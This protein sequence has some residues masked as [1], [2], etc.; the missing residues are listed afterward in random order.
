MAPAAELLEPFL[1]Q[2]DGVAL[3]SQEPWVNS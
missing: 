2:Q 3:F 1:F